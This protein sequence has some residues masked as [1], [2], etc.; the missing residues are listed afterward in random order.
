MRTDTEFA[1]NLDS[2][3]PPSKYYSIIKEKIS[4]PQLQLYLTIHFILMS[5]LT[6]LIV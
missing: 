2:D 1:K 4:N 5:K 3:R 6:Q